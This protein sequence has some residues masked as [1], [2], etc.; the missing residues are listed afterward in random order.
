MYACIIWLG[1]ENICEIIT[2]LNLQLLAHLCS[3]LGYGRSLLSVLS[4]FN[5]SRFLHLLESLLTLTDGAV[6][7]VVVRGS[8]AAFSQEKVFK[9]CGTF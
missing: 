6:P 2:I 8:V 9:N 7:P 5:S 4:A 1:K 3:T